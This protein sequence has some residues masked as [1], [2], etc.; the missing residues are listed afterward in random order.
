MEWGIN[1]DYR[2]IRNYKGKKLN[3]NKKLIFYLSLVMIAIIFIMAISINFTVCKKF[4]EYTS[5]VEGLP[6]NNQNTIDL[7]NSFI[8][9]INNLI[10]G[11]SLLMIIVGIYLSVFLSQKI[12]KPIIVVSKMTDSIKKGGYDQKL[13]YDSSILEI[14]NLINS[15]NNLAY[16]LNHME[17]MR[18][19][20]TSDISHELRT[21]L[22]SIQTHLEAMIDG[23]WEPTEERLNSVNEEV[24][25]LSHLVNQLKNLAKFDNEKNVLNLS[26]TNLTQLIKNIIYNNESYAL[27][28]DIKINSDLEDININ[29]DKEKI[30]QVIVNLISNA[31]RYTC[32]DGNIFIKSYKKNDEVKIHVIDNGRGIPKESLAYIFE[33]FYRVDDSRCRKT[34]GTGVG[35]TICKSIID[36]HHGKIEVISEENKGSEFIVTLPVK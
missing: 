6:K 31:I 36:L 5:L 32:E 17:K 33:R 11:I 2:K 9:Y 28:K 4:T 25:R 1:L 23:I 29:I 10:I 34:G 15:I 7:E 16:E 14:D 27:E 12:S 20:L 8:S 24:I 19:R 26:N 22:T 13:E 18:K 3:L 21:P 30:S 35:L